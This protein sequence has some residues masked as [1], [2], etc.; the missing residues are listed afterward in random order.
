M[1]LEPKHKA[2]ISGE[3]AKRIPV[4]RLDEIKI[5]METFRKKVAQ[6]KE[7]K[8][9]PEPMAFMFHGIAGVGKTEL[10]DMFKEK[11]DGDTNQPIWAKFDLR[12]RFNCGAE[13]ALFALRKELK[14]NFQVEFHAFDVA[15]AFY[16]KK[17]HPQI[18]L[19][20]KTFEHWDD[21]SLL[22]DIIRDLEDLPLIEYGPKIFKFIG[23]NKK[24]LLDWWTKK[25]NPALQ[26]LQ[27]EKEDHKIVEKMPLFFALDLKKHIEDTKRLPVLLFDT[28]EDIWG[29]KRGDDCLTCDEWIRELVLQLPE[30]LWIMAGREPLP[31]ADEDQEWKNYLCQPSIDE[32]SQADSLKY[33]ENCGVVEPEIREAIYD[34]EKKGVPLYLNLQLDQYYKIKSSGRVPVPTDFGKEEREIYDSFLKNLKDEESRTLKVLSSAHFWNR[35]IFELLIKEFDTKFS[36]MDYDEFHNFSF[37]RWNESTQTWTMHELMRDHLQKFMNDKIR[38]E[39]HGFLFN[40]YNDQLI[41]IDIKHITTEQKAA[42]SEAFYHASCFMNA[43][44]LFRWACRAAQPFEDAAQNELPILIYK[45]VI[46]ELQNKGNL[47]AEEA[48]CLNNLAEL[49][50]RDGKYAEAESLYKKALEI[51]KKTIGED[52]ANYAIGMNNLAALYASQGKYADAEP[53]YMQALEIDKKTIG[54]SHTNYANHLSNLAELYRNL[55][56]NADAE[57]LYKK[58]LEID[59]KTVGEDHPKYAIHLN[60]LAELFRIQGKYSDAEPLYKKALEIGKKTIGEDHPNYA[61]RLN[62][63]A[64]LYQNQRKY[65]E[66]EPLYKKA[67]EIDKK[68]IGETH[69]DYAKDLNNLAAL[70]QYRGKYADAE[71]LYMKALDIIKKCLGERHPSFLTVLKNIAIC[72]EAWGN[73]EEARKYSDWVKRIEE[74]KPE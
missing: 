7:Q 50:R 69:P 10:L 47:Q 59:K 6:L 14:D 70:Y 3:K 74:Q 49:Y 32:L 12:G 56:K 22:A 37:I 19:N 29:E 65:A 44:N 11:L 18:P 54:E 64:A 24:R 8:S 31:W 55:G 13:D 45:R 33:L 66:A 53:L 15:Y 60:N 48:H 9:N 71:S 72:Y 39:N 2:G 73:K 38:N 51:A 16:W 17:N 57:P 68:T 1:T 36:M 28:Y 67:L 58:A 43:T 42:L 62:N 5:F 26:T 61:T 23:K 20:K 63:L 21:T 46:I 41:I 52:H 34:G 25:V 30:C 27:A 4:G 35:E 40:F